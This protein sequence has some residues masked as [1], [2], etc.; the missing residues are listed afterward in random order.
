VEERKTMALNNRRKAFC[1]EYV[2]DWNA[3]EAAMRAGYSAHTAKQQ[4]HRLLTNVYCREEIDR[5][6]TDI[7]DQNDVETGEIISGLRRIA[8]APAESKVKDSDRLRAFELLGKYKSIFSERRII[9]T[10]ER[11][12][13]LSESQKA[14]PKRLAILLMNNPD[15]LAART[16]D[17]DKGVE[18][19]G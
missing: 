13:E 4:G 5:L 1:R 19:A 3:K 6:S 18:S 9:E 11:Q 10:P 14:E 17:N 8:F 15:N 2:K 16:P 7:A 12:R